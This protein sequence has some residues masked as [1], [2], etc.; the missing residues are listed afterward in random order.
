MDVLHKPKPSVIGEAHVGGQ[1]AN[2]WASA[3]RGRD[4]AHRQAG[5]SQHLL[6]HRIPRG[7]ELE[8]QCTRQARFWQCSPQSIAVGTKGQPGSACASSQSAQAHHSSPL[9]LLRMQQAS[10]R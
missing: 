7:Q 3:W 1:Q 2:I 8:S 6:L 5:C 4:S 9:L 10:A